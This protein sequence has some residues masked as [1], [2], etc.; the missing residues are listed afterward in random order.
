MLACEHPEGFACLPV[1]A[2]TSFPPH[3]SASRSR[4]RRRRPAEPCRSSSGSCLPASS[5]WPSGSS[6]SSSGDVGGGVADLAF[7]FLRGTLEF[8]LYAFRAEIFRHVLPP[9]MH[10]SLADAIASLTPFPPRLDSEGQTLC[11]L[12]TD[13]LGRMTQ[14]YRADALR[15]L[16]TADWT[17]RE[18]ELRAIVTAPCSSSRRFLGRTPTG[19]VGFPRSIL[20][21]PG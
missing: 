4:L 10:D 14:R 18:C 12:G 6:L 8:V 11:P 9:L 20:Q 21:N 1:P 13:E 17:A 5:L 15:Q 16:R 7:R 19:H 2:C 3:E